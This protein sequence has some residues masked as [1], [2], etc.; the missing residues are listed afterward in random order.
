MAWTYHDYE[1]QATDELRLARLR[2]HIT[3]V[4]AQVQANVSFAGGN[5]RE[6]DHLIEYL[7][8]LRAERDRLQRATGTVFTRARAV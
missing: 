2:C 4:N 6:N 1:E 5:R 3:E 8:V 7:K